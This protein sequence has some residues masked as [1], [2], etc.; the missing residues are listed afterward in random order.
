MKSIKYV[1]TRIFYHY[2]PPDKTWGR[3]LAQIYWYQ[4]LWPVTELCMEI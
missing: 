4:V 1:M 2:I 3:S